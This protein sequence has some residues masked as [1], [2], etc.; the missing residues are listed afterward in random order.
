M[1][2]DKAEWNSSGVTKINRFIITALALVLTMVIVVAVGL[3][4]SSEAETLALFRRHQQEEVLHSRTALEFYLST[5]ARDLE[6]LSNNSSVRHMEPKA[7]ASKV[8]SDSDTFKHDY[9]EGIALTDAAGNPVSTVGREIP[10]GKK[11]AAALAAKATSYSAVGEVFVTLCPVSEGAAHKETSLFAVLAKPVYPLIRRTGGPELQMAG[12]LAVTASLDSVI[13]K[14][15]QYNDLSMMWILDSKGRLIFHSG[16]PGMTVDANDPQS[17]TCRTCHLSLG[18]IDK[19]L[20]ARQGVIDYRSG[21]SVSLTG[22][23][24]PVKFG[25]QTWTLVMDTPNDTI[26]AASSRHFKGTLLLLAVVF[27]AAVLAAAFF[28][29]VQRQQMEAHQAV[30]RQLEQRNAEDSIMRSQQDLLISLSAAAQDALLM[31]DAE[32]NVRFWN[33]AAETVF[34]WREEEALGKSLH[35]LLVPQ[36]YHTPF[37]A[38]LPEF[39]QTGKG[40]AIGKTLELTALRKDGEEFPV[41]LSLNSIQLRGKWCAVGII[42]DVTSRKEMERKIKDYAQLMKILLAGIKN[43]IYYKDVNGKFLGCNEAFET[44][45]G[46]SPGYV[47][48]KT[49]FDFDPPQFATRQRAVDDELLRRPGYLTFEDRLTDSKGQVHNVIVTKATFGDANEE[50]RGIVGIWTDI[51]EQKQMEA[52]LRRAKDQA[53]AAA[54]AKA[55]FLANMSHEIRTPMNGILGMNSLLLDTQLTDE[56][57]QF[58]ETVRSSANALLAVINDILDFSKIEAGKLDFENADFDL[59]STLDDMND[60]LAFR[61]QEKGLEYLCSIDPSVPLR[62]HGDSGRLRQVLTNLVGNAIKFTSQGE[63]RIDVSTVEETNSNATLRFQ[64]KDTGIGIAEEKREALFQPF[65]QADASTTRQ[66]GGTGLGLAISRH[67]VALM[68]GEIGMESTLGFGSTFWFTVTLEKQPPEANIRVHADIRNVRILVV[69]DHPTNRDLLRLLLTSW[70]CRSH[71]VENGPA[72]LEALRDA[73]ASDDPYQIA[74]LDMAMPGMDGEMLAAKIK[75]DELLSSTQLI[76]LTSLMSR[77]DEG[78]LQQKVFVACISK[79]VRSSRLFDILV[80]IAGSKDGIVLETDAQ[81]QLYTEMQPE[82]NASARILVAEDNPINQRVALHLLAKLGY[83]AE[84]VP[85]GTAA[86]RALAEI[87]FDLVLMDVQM[88]E[89]DGFEATAR[90]RAGEA[91]P[92]KSLIPIIA[93][94]AHAMKGDYEACIHAGMND[95]VTK[96]VNPEALAKAIRGQLSPSAGKSPSCIRSA[97]SK[98]EDVFD[99]SGALDRLGGDGILLNEIIG[100]FIEDAARQIGQLNR[101]AG[102]KDAKVLR[103]QAHALKGASG[104]IGALK[105]QTVAA[106]IEAAGKRGDLR[107]AAAMLPRL[108]A[109]FSRF[110]LVIENRQTRPEIGSPPHSTGNKDQSANGEGLSDSSFS[111]FRTARLNTTVLPR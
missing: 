90:I 73:V 91:S 72:A 30:Q 44:F 2:N 64:V 77:G 67:L 55:M 16:H 51:G 61:A 37:E 23:F 93:M 39:A 70:G 60:L 5:L 35:K 105:M 95:Y 4:K 28:L 1:S 63:V 17:K 57:R 82:M 66:Y 6:M 59:Q 106:E 49:V 3:Y 7:F 110:R 100:I 88:P 103:E 29:R 99:K 20:A 98:E 9:I 87:P 14:D 97:V 24:A 79:P 65:V 109:E 21:K 33:H 11:L 68:G 81:K 83:R 34:G 47:I 48:G 94:T 10:G 58:A 56:Q 38:G 85:T 50:I 96:P 18:H 54:R 84:A 78:L 108:Q 80:Q 86:I 76:L 45:K 19:I 107:S 111:N 32:G 36:K 40:A 101:A 15:L 62:L 69:D 42:R 102:Q 46:F 74:I 43:P 27:S 71:E 12:M 92:E 104:S 31:M 25:D 13:R 8:F 52:T 89:M 53:E 75:Q 22:A 26:S 41:E